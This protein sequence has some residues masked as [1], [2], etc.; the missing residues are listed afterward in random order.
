MGRELELSEIRRALDSSRL[1]T[2]TG[3]G[4]SGKTRLAVEAAGRMRD[5]FADGAA[6]VDLTPLSDARRLA[7]HVGAALGLG[8]DLERSPFEILTDRLRPLGLLLVLDNCEHLVE[9]CAELAQ[10]LLTACPELRILATSREALGIAAE[11]AW[12]VPPLSLPASADPPTAAGIE[13]SEAVQLFLGRAQ[14]VQP[15][16][17]LTDSNADAVARICRQLDGIPLAIE[18]AAARVKVLPPEEIASRL[19]DVFGLLTTRSRTALPRHRTLRDAIDWSHDLLDEPEQVLFR[20][21]AVFAG[22]FSLEAAESLCANGGEVASGEVLD[23]LTALVDKSLVRAEPRQGQGRFSLLEPVRQYALE[24][25]REAGE[26]E[27]FRDRHA[28]YYLSLAERAEPHIRGGTRGTEWMARLEAD[29]A[30][31]RAAAEWL[32]AD[33]AR[34]ELQLRLITALC[35]FFFAQGIF[36]EP[37][38][39]LERALGHARGADHAVVGRAYV[40]LGYQAYW[41]GDEAAVGPYLGRAV[42]LLRDGDDPAA[43]SFALTGLGLA[44]GLAGDAAAAHRLFEEAQ[45][46]LGGIEGAR[47]RGF[48]YLLPHAFADYW[49]GV[50]ALFHG[51]PARARSSFE[52]S[53]GAGRALSSHPSIA[54]PL[55]ALARLHTVEGDFA[56]ARDCLS[57]SLPIHARHDDRWG[58]ADA[59]E[60]AA[61]LAAA[62]GEPERAARLLGASDGLRDSTGLGLPPHL[63]AARARLLEV[64]RE[65]L[66]ADALERARARGRGMTVGAALDEALGRAAT[67]ATGRRPALAASE[68]AGAGATCGA[69]ARRRMEAAAGPP[70]TGAGAGD[71]GGGGGAAGGDAG[72]RSVGALAAPPR[73]AVA[74]DE[75]PDLEVYALGPLRVLRQGR[76]L[77]AG[78]WGSFKPK[79]LLLYLLCRP[80][81]ATRDQVGLALWPDAGGDRLGNSFH[82]TLHRL[83]KALGNGE[84][85]TRLGE[86][87]AI[88]P[89]ITCRFDAEVFEFEVSG[90]LI[91][92][93]RGI[94]A[95]DR[96]TAALGLWRGP[97]LDQ[98][99]V[100]DWHLEVHDR[101]RR[102]HLEGR[103]A[104]GRLH[105]EAGRHDLAAEAYRRVI[106]DDDLHEEAYRRLMLCLARTGD[107]SQALRLFQK[108]TA[109]LER[110]VGARPEP[111]TV[112][113]YERLRSGETV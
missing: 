60:A 65:A 11:T 105:A 90:A 27:A 43:L 82:V 108:L 48:P 45:S 102:L 15:G 78:A 51:N 17:V 5:D 14:A 23:L 2:L 6:W 91:D 85:V 99:I 86:R 36:R 3:P 104:L 61:Q 59:L 54:H 76:E 10:E 46:E 98:E 12:C 95:V 87:Y 20:R 55:A 35:W 8:E 57:E 41:Q 30:N 33:P 58:L 9:G 47:A 25:L 66:G 79:E 74:H 44:T 18:L 28:V 22:R 52:A 56:A 1:V 92:L 37:R 50:V 7:R 16:F 84:W 42:T 21:L 31:L 73:P 111:A 38:E 34:A 89:A 81:G 112:E 97:F 39:R 71:G 109:L 24:K 62:E 69:T 88:N 70:A 101:L 103:M 64:M 80:D 63:L 13:H 77:A 106:A 107:R 75:T 49:R 40:A 26:L 94:P 53:I 110:D 72:E 113:I 100:G 29:G 68:P 67:P 93:R 83:R 4:G 32:G 96:L 19:V